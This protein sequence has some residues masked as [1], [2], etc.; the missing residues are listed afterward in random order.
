MYTS[1]INIVNTRNQQRDRNNLEHH[2]I[3]G[4]KWGIRRFQNEDGTLTPKG[5]ER[6]LATR[7]DI[8]S[9]GEPVTTAVGDADLRRVDLENQAKRDVITTL[10]KNPIYRTGAYIGAGGAATA[11]AMGTIGALGL[12]NPVVAAATAAGLGVF[13]G[14]GYNV[15]KN[16]AKKDTGLDDMDSWT[17]ENMKKYQLN[18]RNLGYDVKWMSRQDVAKFKNQKHHRSQIDDAWRTNYE[19]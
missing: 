13:G 8:N 9:Q 10:L 1:A 6:Y 3:L 12:V 19:M 7:I 2:G 11:A 15:A 18:T 5:K 4:M 14:V 16:E 17:R